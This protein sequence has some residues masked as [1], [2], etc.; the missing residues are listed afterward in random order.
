MTIMNETSDMIGLMK[1]IGI[2]CC[3]TMEVLL[4]EYL[5]VTLNLCFPCMC[6]NSGRNA[7]IHP[8]AQPK[9]KK[10]QVGNLIHSM[11]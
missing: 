1:P 3:C 2:L 4:A 11:W 10:L 6:N 5:I 8:L 7:S 9:C